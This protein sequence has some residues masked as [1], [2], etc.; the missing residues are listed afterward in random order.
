V[1]L[2]TIRIK[3]KSVEKTL[4][5]AVETMKSIAAGKRV[6]SRTGEYFENLEAVRSVLTENRLNLLKLIRTNKPNSVAELAR[7]AKRDFKH[8]HGDVEILQGL[9]LIQTT[10]NRQGKATRLSSDTTEIVFKIAV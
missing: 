10:V 3:L 7:I 6:T 2:K 1:A 4:D 9:G 8:V 5:D